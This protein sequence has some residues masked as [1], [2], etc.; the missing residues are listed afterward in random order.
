MINLTD[1]CCKENPN[2]FCVQ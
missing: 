1:K 2:T